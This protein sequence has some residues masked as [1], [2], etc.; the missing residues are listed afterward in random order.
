MKLYS[1]NVL[2]D[3]SLVLEVPRPISQKES[4]GP[5]DFESMKVFIDN[6]HSSSENCPERAYRYWKFSFML[7]S[8][9]CPSW[10]A[11]Q[12]M[13]SLRYFS[14]DK[15]KWL[16]KIN[17]RSKRSILV[18]QPESL[19]KWANF[20]W[21]KMPWTHNLSDIE[22]WLLVQDATLRRYCHAVIL[23]VR[24]NEMPTPRVPKSECCFCSD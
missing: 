5:S 8:L 2:L 19:L 12:S 17:H 10:L 14:D 4:L 24:I 21:K 23:N 13:C 16:A 7:Y 15:I 1:Q 20:L 3:L 9:F 22:N 6:Y 18:I 11:S